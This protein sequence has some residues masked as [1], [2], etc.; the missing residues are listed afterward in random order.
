MTGLQWDE[1]METGDPLVDQQHRDIH[2]LVDYVEAADDR[3]ERIMEVL[4]RLM[5]HVDCHFMTEEQLMERSGYGGQSAADHIAE[6]R[7]L[8]DAAR[9][10]VLRFRSGELTSMKPVVAFVREWFAGHV[11]EHDRT[12]V[13]FVRS[14]AMAAETP[15]PWVSNPP[16]EVRPAE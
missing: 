1:S 15:E 16:A 13:E 10:A 4:D 8:T 5:E 12:F 11:Y 6:H 3:P 2:A 7:E 9:Q 14:R